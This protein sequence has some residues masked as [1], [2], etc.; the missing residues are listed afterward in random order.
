MENPGAA[1]NEVLDILE[2]DEQYRDA[3]ESECALMRLYHFGATHGGAF[4]DESLNWEN[5]GWADVIDWPVAKSPGGDVH[6][7]EIRISQTTILSVLYG[8]IWQNFISRIAL[9]VGE[10]EHIPAL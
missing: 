9:S 5:V 2:L 8:V 1:P 10:D 4:D 3:I 7:G 6:L